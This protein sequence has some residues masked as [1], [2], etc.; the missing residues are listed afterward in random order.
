MSVSPWRGLSRPDAPAGALSWILLIIFLDMMGLGLLVPVIPL[1]V[2]EFQGDAMVIGWLSLAYAAAQFLATPLLCAWSDRHGRRGIMLLSFLGSAFAYVAFGWAPAL[3]VLFAGRIVDGLTGA[4]IGTSQAYIA[5]ITAPEHRSR[6]LAM[7]GA[8]LGAGFIVG[9]LTG[10]GLS[11][12]GHHAPAFVAAGLTIASTA[13]AWWRLPESLPAHIRAA[14]INWR[15]LNP[16]APLQAALK[17]PVLRPLLAAAFLANF[18]MAALRSH[19]AFFAIIVLGYTQSDAN[20]VIA[21]LGVMMVIAQGGLV[22]RA[23]ERW[24][25]YGTLVVGLG[26]SAVGFGGLSI[27]GSTPMLYV[28]VAVTALGVGL[29]TPTMAALVSHRSAAVEQGAMLGA[30][31]AAASLAQVL[32]PVWAGF[33]FVKWGPALPFSSGAALVVTAL[34]VV[35]LHRPSARSNG[36]EPQGRS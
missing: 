26:L 27:A 13:L 1:I 7:A 36:A 23:V 6:A 18:A 9:P 15:D 31:Q 30:A 4:N 17:R 28:M 16:L 8:A 11:R 32:G 35:M 2:L 21:F 29:G 20:R 22:R 5:D 34:I 24:G 14:A 33:V 3:W 12:L 10:V 19:F 25:D